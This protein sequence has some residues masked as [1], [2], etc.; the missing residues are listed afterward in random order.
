MVC[1]SSGILISL[2]ELFFRNKPF[3]Y[4]GDQ[5]NEELILYLLNE[6]NKSIFR[7]TA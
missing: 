7:E 5:M 3:N 1:F 4:R 2:N 6:W